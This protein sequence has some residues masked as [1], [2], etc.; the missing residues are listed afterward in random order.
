MGGWRKQDLSYLIFKVYVKVEVEDELGKKRP[1]S[2]CV[3]QGLTGQI[4]AWWRLYLVLVI[5][6]IYSP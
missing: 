1:L 4:S 3:D 5:S 6:M 2:V